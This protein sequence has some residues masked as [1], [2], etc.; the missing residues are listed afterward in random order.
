MALPSEGALLDWFQTKL[1]RLMLEEIAD[2]DRGED[3]LQTACLNN[4]RL[5]LASGIA[6]RNQRNECIPKQSRRGFEVF[7][8]D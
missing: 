4:R 1:S 8:I 6:G 2:N 3:C 7:Q 5:Q